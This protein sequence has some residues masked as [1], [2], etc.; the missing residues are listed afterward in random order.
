MA[1]K[2][3]EVK[4]SLTGN[5]I[6]LQRVKSQLGGDGRRK[7][8]SVQR[9]LS[10]QQLKLNFVLDRLA[11]HKNKTKEAERKLRAALRARGSS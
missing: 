8:Q 6:K 5:D 2:V 7:V 11:F 9:S 10:E 3:R 4:R 1:T